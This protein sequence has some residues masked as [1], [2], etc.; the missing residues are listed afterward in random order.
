MRRNDI[1]LLCIILAVSLA[2]LAALYTWFWKPSETVVVTVDGEEILR[3]PLDEDTEIW[4]DGYDGGKNLLVIEDGDAYVKEAN[5]PDLVCV[6]TGK[7][8]ELKSVVCAPS[9]LV[10]YLEKP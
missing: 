2:A 10:V 7:A 9:R 3:L 5:C 4:I 1:I 8:T 6:H